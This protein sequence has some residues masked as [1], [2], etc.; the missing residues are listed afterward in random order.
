[1]SLSF[2]NFKFQ[3][4]LSL[5]IIYKIT[6][7]AI[8]LLKFSFSSILNMT[9]SKGY[10]RAFNI[11]KEKIHIA[12]F[13]LLFLKMLVSILIFIKSF[14]KTKIFFVFKTKMR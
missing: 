11:L 7:I 13:S 3:P 14:I 10:F 9:L 1:M 12:A 4:T 8:L 6:F 5:H 2:N